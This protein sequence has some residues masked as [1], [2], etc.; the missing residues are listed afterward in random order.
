[1]RVSGN[2]V[3]TTCLALAVACGCS[4]VE[5]AAGETAPRTSSLLS[6]DF[7]TGHRSWG[8]PTF[9]LGIDIALLP[10]GDAVVAG[11]GAIPPNVTNLDIEIL[12]VGSN[13]VSWVRAW[14]SGFGDFASAIGVGPDGDTYVAGFAQDA[15]GAHAMVLL[16]LDDA[17][18]ALWNKR[19]DLDGDVEA[20]DLAFDGAGNVVVAGTAGQ[21]LVLVKLTPSG[22]QL[23]AKTY[24]RGL[25]RDR[26]TA[27]AVDAG[28]NVIVVGESPTALLILK[29]DPVGNLLWAREWGSSA[30]VVQT[31][32]SSGVTTDAAGN[33][34]VAGFSRSTVPPVAKIDP[35]LIKL[36]PDGSQIWATTETDF[37]GTQY[38]GVA[39][40]GN[41]RLVVSGW[42]GGLLFLVDRFDTDGTF[43]Q[44]QT[45]TGL[46]SPDQNF[47]SPAVGLAVSPSGNALIVGTAP[48]AAGSWGVASPTFTSLADATSPTAFTTQTATLS[49]LAG[50]Q[51]SD[52][53]TSG[54]SDSGGGSVDILVVG[55]TPLAPTPD[56]GAGGVPVGEPCADPDVCVSGSACVDGVCCKDAALCAGGPNDCLACSQAAGGTKNGTCTPVIAGRSCTGDD[57]CDAPGTCARDTATCNASLLP[58]NMCS[59]LSESPQT[60]CGYVDSN[61]PACI[62]FSN[63]P[64]ADGSALVKLIVPYAGRIKLVD[65]GPGCAP[66]TGFQVVG[67]NH[68]WD[69]ETDPT[70][71][72]PEVPPGTELFNICFRYN[73]SW[74]PGLENNLFIIHGATGSCSSGWK[75]LD[76][77]TINTSSNEI[78]A[79]SPSLSPFTV[80]QPLPDQIPVVTVPADMTVGAASTAGAVASFAASAVDP[81][82]GPLGSTCTPASASPF[83]I[84]ATLVTCTAVDSQQITGQASFSLRVSYDA[85]TDGSFF[86]QPINP[87]NSSIFKAGSTIGV[88]FKLTGASA[89][90]TNLV[91][92]I[93]VARISSGVMGTYVETTSN[94]APDGGNLFRYDATAGQYIY[95]LSTKDMATGTW[96]LRVDLGDGIDH[97]I[98]VSLK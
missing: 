13:G 74:V 35:I 38:S 33:V 98:V 55:F 34:Y 73:D 47:G 71:P 94:A 48:A 9:D 19:L 68:Y 88:K 67:A 69:F 85:P 80:V 6:T 64:S 24:D 46:P 62:P 97:A 60:D 66:P 23:W 40:D 21:R 14:D 27:V 26:A 36:T 89:G 12:R 25:P 10:S 84:G 37:L 43:L 29:T 83:P 82:D 11:E 8:G 20:V 49:T 42:Q 50:G 32:S 87:D 39:L 95:N 7:G 53:T 3:A 2:V 4:R 54:V 28:G 18:N 72:L 56:G 63:W 61:Y 90:I 78:C 92:H 5:G 75:P 44:R 91:A 30:S 81:Q 41:G 76:G 65:A 15:S 93:S 59:V 70:V 1:M 58:T 17:G 45:W 86:L 51:L 22:A 16:K 79:N 57:F 52:V 77:K 96:S 31:N